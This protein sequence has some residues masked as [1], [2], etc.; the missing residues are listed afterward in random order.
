MGKLSFK[1]KIVFPLLLL[2][3]FIAWRLEKRKRL[4]KLISTARAD[5][6]YFELYRLVQFGI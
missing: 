1:K 6:Y 2:R 3:T 4:E 5:L